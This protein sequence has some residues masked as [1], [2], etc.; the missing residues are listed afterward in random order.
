M[1]DLKLGLK[2]GPAVKCRFLL[3]FRE[4]VRRADS[5]TTAVYQTVPPRPLEEGMPHATRGHNREALGL[6]SSHREQG[7]FPAVPTGRAR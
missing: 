5:D 2:S 6:V 4:M 7:A 3:L 1:Y